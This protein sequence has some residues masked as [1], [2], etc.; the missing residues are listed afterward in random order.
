MQSGTADL[1]RRLMTTLATALVLVGVFG[2]WLLSGS[3]TRSSF[4][5]IDL[6]GRLG[7]SPGGMFEIVLRLWALVPLL[8]VATCVAVWAGRQ[9][10]A[11]VLGLVSGLYVGGVSA[12]VAQAPDAS[13]V[14][15]SWGV[16]VSAIGAGALIAVSCWQ[17]AAR[18]SAR[19]ESSLDEHIA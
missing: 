9:R 8:V 13:L 18:R 6:V 1:V 12:A 15:T 4:E 3:S 19:P 17:L 11:A 14:R 5:L 2:P 16:E 7:F 10:L